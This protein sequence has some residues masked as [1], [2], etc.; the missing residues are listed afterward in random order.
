MAAMRTLAL[1]LA[2]LWDSFSPGR[3]LT[4]VALTLF[5][6][7]AMLAIAYWGA[8][9][10]Y[11]PLLTNLAPADA[12]ELVTAIEKERVPFQIADGG[13]ALLVPAD[14]VHRLRLKL[15]GEGLPKGGGVGFELFNNADFGMS[16]FAE[17]VNY[18]RALE[19][20][21]QRTIRSL[22]AVQDARVHIV[23]AERSLFG[24]RPDQGRASVTLHL[25]RGHRLSAEQAQA[26]VHLVA[27]SVPELSPEN[28]TL[29]DSAGAVLAK[30]GDSM[31]GAT[32]AFD[33]QRSIERDLEERLTGI[34]ERTL[35]QGGASVRVAAE[36]DASQSEKTSETFDPDG[37]VLRSE[38]VSAEQQGAP[39]AAATGIPGARSNLTGVA[40]P[41]KPG[42]SGSARTAQTKNY[43]VS[44][45]VSREVRPTGRLRRLSVAV[46]VD[47]ARLPT[48][49][50]A[51][52]VTTL[53]DLVRKAIGFDEARGDQVVVQAAPF[54]ATPV[55]DAPP[56]DIFPPV[57]LP[58][59]ERFGR[60]ALAAAVVLGIAM[61][62]LR[63]RP[64]GAA[65]RPEIF[66]TPRTVREIEA[67]M[68]AQAVPGLP[69]AR[70]TAHADPP[71][72]AA[73]LRDWLEES[74]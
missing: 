4:V 16:R 36:I 59:L 48:T 40:P 25:R 66:A 71:K 56:G 57:W 9:A 67:A 31:R 42:E 74:P 49:A 52:D 41:P 58:W 44:K 23:V 73:V 11:A 62:L 19:G 30:G 45:V 8:Q 38:Q 61:L 7:G 46:L 34:L 15:A 1:Q 29:I 64:G 33:Q 5:G 54:S 47:A 35:G 39:L 6:L 14:Q 63:R 10:T 27:S 50:G 43:E 68:S 69:P 26:I 18:R 28:V 65:L 60:P 70:A 37:F 24:E 21:L 3:R 17:Q 20:E 55:A 53:T 22:D 72:A 2:A 51:P 13:T 32:A 12:A